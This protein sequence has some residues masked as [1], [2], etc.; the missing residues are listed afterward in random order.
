M[1]L[2]R[3]AHAFLPADLV[4]TSLSPAA[5]RALGHLME[6][7]RYEYQSDFARKYYGQGL[8]EG[9]SKGR[10][11]GRSEDRADSLRRLSPTAKQRRIIGCSDTDQLKRWF[12]RALAADSVEALFA[13]G[14]EPLSG[15]DG[16][17]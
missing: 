12:I 8:I 13:D 4:W 5:L 1:G 2:M 10:A 17:V 6:S 11:E 3:N 15:T 7:G 14:R 16:T 9:E